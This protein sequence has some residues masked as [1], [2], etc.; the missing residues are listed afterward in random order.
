MALKR[1]VAAF[2]CG[3]SLPMT[4]EKRSKYGEPEAL[5]EI[6]VRVLSG[7]KFRLDCGHYVSF[8]HNLG[9]DITVLNGKRPKVICSL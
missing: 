2:L 3:R 7:K 1:A 5:R 6:L 4:K 9:N 8:G